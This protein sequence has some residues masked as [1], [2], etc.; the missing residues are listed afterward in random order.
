MFFEQEGRTGPTT[1]IGVGD[2]MSPGR[3]LLTET[4]EPDNI[5]PSYSQIFLQAES[6]L[7]S[8][9]TTIVGGA[10]GGV[11]G[12]EQIAAALFYR[13]LEDIRGKDAPARIARATTVT[14]ARFDAFAQLADGLKKQGVIQIPE[15]MPQ[16][17][18]F[19]LV[20]D[21]IKRT[22]C[23]G[24]TAMQAR[25]E[26][27]IAELPAMQAETNLFVAKVENSG[28]RTMVFP[29]VALV[30][31]IKLTEA[32][33]E[34]TLVSMAELVD[35]GVGSA[36]NTSGSV[37]ARI[38]GVVIS[39]PHSAIGWGAEVLPDAAIPVAIA[40][41]AGA[42]LYAYFSLQH[43]YPI[44]TETFWQN[45]LTGGFMGLLAGT[46]PTVIFSRFTRRG[47]RQISSTT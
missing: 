30:E 16:D 13:I 32:I 34:Q 21:G 29:R 2:A 31:A 8:A 20:A 6:L 9:L 14:L 33:G 44:T 24:V 40:T 39:L 19:D 38:I 41:P 45:T 22:V 23:A 46:I 11:E 4:L 18:L 17:Q 10:F 36:I 12:G 35:R 26:I 27:A 5:R 47:K 37:L 28:R 43:G 7:G 3:K 15:G 1:G 42:L 25:K